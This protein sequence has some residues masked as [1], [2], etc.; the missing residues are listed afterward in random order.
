M[1]ELIDSAGKVTK[2]NELVICNNG[3]PLILFDRKPKG[4]DIL[5][6]CPICLSTLATKKY[7]DSIPN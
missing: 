3:H 6:S 5:A 7:L 2:F 4:A 1:I